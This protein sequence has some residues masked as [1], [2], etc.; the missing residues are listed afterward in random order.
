M[1]R[2]CFPPDNSFILPEGRIRRRVF[3]DCVHHIARAGHRKRE[4]ASARYGL[5]SRCPAWRGH[6]IQGVV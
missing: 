3:M 4:N 5:E 2:G 1:N 6:S